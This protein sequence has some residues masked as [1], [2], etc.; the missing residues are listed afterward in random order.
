MQTSPARRRV[1]QRPPF[2]VAAVQHRWHPDAKEHRAALAEGVRAAAAE[3]ARLVCLQELTLSPYF[4][5]VE[6]G[7]QNAA[8]HAED[9]ATGPTFAFAADLAAETGT[10]VHA[11]LYER[12]ADDPDG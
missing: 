8:A 12:V 7:L 10:Y 3:G 4:A 1:A 6:D 5:I 11:S 9:I 2:R